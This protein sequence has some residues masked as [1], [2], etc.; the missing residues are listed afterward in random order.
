MRTLHFCYSHE[1]VDK[2]KEIVDNWRKLALNDFA[3]YFVSQWLSGK[4]TAWQTFQTPAGYASTSN[5]VE[6]FNHTLKKLFTKREKLTVD[7]F[8]TMALDDLIPFYAII[9]KRK[10]LF[11]NTPSSECRTKANEL[12][13]EKFV[14][15]SGFLS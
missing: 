6:S 9:N 10:F 7:S 14:G 2:R 4:F 13:P 5:P 12:N 15:S 3:D 1:F 8:V 11:Y